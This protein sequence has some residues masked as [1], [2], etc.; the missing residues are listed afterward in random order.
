MKKDKRDQLDETDALLQRAASEPADVPEYLM[1]RVLNDADRTQAGFSAV[2][3][4][5]EPGFITQLREAMGGWVGVS[6][7]AAASCVG[8]WFGVSPPGNVPDALDLLTGTEVYSS[9]YETGDISGFGWD[10]A[11]G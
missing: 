10:L 4:G 6:G 1:T 2:P 11:G 3:P 7:L 9:Y 5:S 8:F